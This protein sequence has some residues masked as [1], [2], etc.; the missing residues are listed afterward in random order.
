MTKL[1]VALVAGIVGVAAGYFA[2]RSGSP[3]AGNS[4]SESGTA[5]VL[6]IGD[7][8]VSGT[9]NA[10]PLI[11]AERS[12]EYEAAEKHGSELI[13]SIWSALDNP[14]ESERERAFAKLIENMRPEDALAV[15]GVFLDGDKQGRWFIPEWGH[16]WTKWGEVDGSAGAAYLLG[17][18]DDN[19]GYRSAARHLMSTWVEDD[20]EG[21]KAWIAATDTDDS[22]LGDQLVASFVRAYALADSD[23]ATEYATS[24]EEG[25]Q[26]DQALSALVG[27]I[28]QAEGIGGVEK[29]L[30]TVPVELTP[31]MATSSSRVYFR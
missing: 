17:E 8:G 3:N 15:R 23:A 12:T 29:W 6:Q 27:G 11:A 2:G 24:L 21:A 22:A 26:R 20:V 13:S 30:S 1:A 4:A 25:R 19:P 18:K 10:A 28:V 16:F 5:R 7:Q 9:P 14:N 31:E